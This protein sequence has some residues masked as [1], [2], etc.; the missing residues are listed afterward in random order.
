MNNYITVTEP[1]PYQF[2]GRSFSFIERDGDYWFIATEIANEL[3]HRNAH[4]LTRILDDDEKGTHQVRTLGGNQE[5]S[6]ISEAGLYRAIVQ[7]RAGKKQDSGLHKRI[8]RF[9]RWVF[10]EVLPSIR[11]TGSYNSTP[12]IEP[13]NNLD[14]PAVL[15]PLLLTH[16]KARQ[17][18]EAKVAEQEPKVLAFDMIAKSEGS[19]TLTETAKT[20]GINR[21]KKLIPYLNRKW[22]FRI[23]GTGPWVGYKPKEDQELVYNIVETITRQDGSEKTVTRVRITPKGLAQLAKELAPDMFH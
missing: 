23:G 13:I 15:L 16:L 17:V 1:M 8:A 10:H 22:I 9:Q 3:G 12:T 4:D 14:D 2:D 11:K 6:I 20:L 18:A 19:F 7:R 5:I 21:D